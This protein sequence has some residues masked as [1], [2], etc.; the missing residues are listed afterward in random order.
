MVW[1]SSFWRPSQVLCCVYVWSTHREHSKCLLI[2][3]LS[4]KY[5]SSRDVNICHALT[6]RRLQR[7][8]CCKF[9]CSANSGKNSAIGGLNANTKCKILLGKSPSKLI[10]FSH[11]ILNLSIFYVIF[12]DCLANLNNSQTEIPVVIPCA[13]NVDLPLVIPFTSV[14]FFLVYI[15]WTRQ[16][17]PF[18]WR[19][20]CTVLNYLEYSRYSQTS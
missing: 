19:N 2:A 12:L 17:R 1:C 13:V 16:R 15:V 8:T 4:K 7:K 9:D 5:Y 10:Y 11:L 20:F 6:G 18:L 3:S 14:I